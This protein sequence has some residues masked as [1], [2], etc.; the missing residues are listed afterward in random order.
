M[1]TTAAGALT[2]ELLTNGAGQTIERDIDIVTPTSGMASMTIGNGLSGTT[3]TLSGTTTLGS[4]DSAVQ[5]VTLTAVSGSEFDVTGNIQI[6]SGV[7]G[8]GTGDTVVKT[9]AGTVVLAGLTNYQGGTTV[10]QGTL[11]VTGTAYQGG[12]YT[13]QSGA[14]LGGAGGTINTSNANV[15][16]NAGG[17]LDIS[18]QKTGYAIT[19][20][21]LALNLGSGALDI[22]PAVTGTSQSLSFALATTTTSDEVA[23]GTGSTLK[24]GSGVMGIGDFSFTINSGFGAGQYILFDTSSASGINGTLGSNLTTTIDGYS[25]TLAEGIDLSGDQDIVLNVAGVPEPSILALLTVGV[26][27]MLASS[28]RLRRVC[29]A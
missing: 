12:S 2:A 4:A 6:N 5:G 16:V 26:F 22:S 14:S 7:T 21:T 8:V 1:G 24:I 28:R 11:L 19:P 9:G 13:V 3:S 20:G 29:L 10:S 25:A 15:T 23:L 17:G 27:F 18:G